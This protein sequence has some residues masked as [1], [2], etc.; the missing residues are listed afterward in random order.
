MTA[1]LPTEETVA[2]AGPTIEIQ[3]L[4]KTFGKDNHILKGVNLTVN[5]GEDVVILG[6]SG[7]GKS[8]TINCIV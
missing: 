7:T 1:P 3:N 5:K 8:I 4:H 6:K 2:K